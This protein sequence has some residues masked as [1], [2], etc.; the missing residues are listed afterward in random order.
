MKKTIF[1]SILLTAAATTATAKDICLKRSLHGIDDA[2]NNEFLMLKNIK[3]LKKVGITI[4]ITGIH[5]LPNDP[6]R[7]IYPFTGG[8]YVSQNGTITFSYRGLVVEGA[9]S[10]LAG[11]NDHDGGSFG[12]HIY[13][14]ID[15]KT[16]PAY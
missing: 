14:A 5:I 3:P 16:I 7:P 13:T 10:E 1:M 9:T 12:Q 2:Q 11:G 6:T 15:C 4:P 8:A